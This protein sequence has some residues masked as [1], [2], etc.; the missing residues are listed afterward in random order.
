MTP[1]TVARQA[2]CP[3]LSPRVCSDSCLLSR[4]AIQPSHPLSRLSPPALHLSQHQ[5]YRIKHIRSFKIEFIDLFCVF[6]FQMSY[7]ENIEYDI[8]INLI[9]NLTF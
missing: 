6:V 1:W 7:K 4:D 8:A 9:W 5:K 2:S 3:S